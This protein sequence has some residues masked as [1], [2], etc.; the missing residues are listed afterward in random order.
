VICRWS[1]RLHQ[2]PL[3]YPVLLPF[4]HEIPRQYHPTVSF[5]F[6]FVVNFLPVPLVQISVRPNNYNPPAS[7]SLHVLLPTIIIVTH[8]DKGTSAPSGLIRA[9]YRGALL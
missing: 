4:F 3:R 2:P 8:S 7:T 1:D 5:D 6:P 9:Y